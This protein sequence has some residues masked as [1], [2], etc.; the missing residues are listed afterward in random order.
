LQFQLILQIANKFSKQQTNA[1][2]N[3]PVKGI[4]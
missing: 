4:L 2:R 3:S 1:K